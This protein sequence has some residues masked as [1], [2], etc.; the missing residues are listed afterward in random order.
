MVSAEALGIIKKVSTNDISAIFQIVF[1]ASPEGALAALM[2]GLVLPAALIEVARFSDNPVYVVI[3]SRPI[4][5]TEPN[6]PRGDGKKPR[7]KTAVHD[8]GSR[9]LAIDP[10]RRPFLGPS[11]LLRLFVCDDGHIFNQFFVIVKTKIQI[12]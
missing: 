1:I 4:R 3:C 11:G 10:R 9:S 8:S 12:I 5:S 2:G 6:I 7:L